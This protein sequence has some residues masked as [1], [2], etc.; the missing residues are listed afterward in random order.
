MMTV[1]SLGSGAVGMSTMQAKGLSKAQM[2]ALM[3][4]IS[5][6]LHQLSNPTSDYNAY[7]TTF[8][9]PGIIMLFIF[10]ITT[11]AIGTELKF[12]H[13][14]ELVEMGGGRIWVSIIGKYLPHTACRWSLEDCAAKR[15]DGA[16]SPGLWH[17]YLRTDAFAAHVNEYQLVVGGA[18]YLYGGC[19]LSFDGHGRSIAGPVVAFPA[20]SLLYG[21]FCWRT[22]RIPHYGCLVAYR[23]T[24]RLYAVAYSGSSED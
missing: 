21:L 14:R 19:C 3:S 24:H 23:R 1:A 12:D 4:P 18:Q 8:M 6:D 11:Y 16:F 10:L 13:G 22:E 15:A 2:A 7:L 9:V 5:I 20:T 17:L